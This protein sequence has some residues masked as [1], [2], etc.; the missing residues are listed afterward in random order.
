MGIRRASVVAALALALVSCSDRTTTP[1][2][3]VATSQIPP[4]PK[5]NERGAIVAQQSADSMYPAIAAIGARAFTVTY[6]S[7][8]GVDGGNADVTGAVFAPSGPPPDGGWPVVTVGH[9]TT[10][11]ADDCAPSRSADLLGN[12]N[13]VIRLLQR[14]F[15]VALTDFQGLG[16]PGPH[17]YL[18]PNSAAFDLIDAVRAARAVI[19]ETSTRWAAIGISQGGQASW[20][21]AEHAGDYGDGLQ[22]VGSANLSPAADVSGFATGSA[23]NLS[24]PQELFLPL[25]IAGMQV[26]HPEL[27]PSAY[28]RG[29]LADNSAALTSCSQEANL[30]KRSIATQIGKDDAQPHSPADTDRMRGWLQALALPKNRAAGPMLVVVGETDN[31]IRPEWTE[32][33]VKRACAIGDVIALHVR[34][35]EGH[36]NPKAIPEAVDWIGDR[37]TGLPA[38]STCESS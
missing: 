27:D 34:A 26:L 10:G 37:F 30:Q 7:T 36:A 1:P 6:R 20:A 38:P 31:V 28:M 22:F 3:P 33:A 12:A 18:E 25:V 24:L 21:A 15:V 9:P 17:P 8:S 14:G 35:G 19:P 11:V 29:L 2:P 23:V 13:L 16:T 5:G 32:A 4:A